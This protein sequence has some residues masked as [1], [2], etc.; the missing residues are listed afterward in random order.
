MKSNYKLLLTSATDSTDC[1]SEFF[2]F[3]SSLTA[4]NDAILAQAFVDTCSQLYHKQG[5]ELL[6]V[7]E[8]DM[9]G[10]ETRFF[11]ANPPNPAACQLQA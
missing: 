10:N 9:F 11:Q 7:W 5:R 8:L 4:A 3:D 1:D 6:C 2:S